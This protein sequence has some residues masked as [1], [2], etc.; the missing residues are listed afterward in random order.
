MRAIKFI[1]LVISELDITLGVDVHPLRIKIEIKTK[2]FIYTTS[3]LI[4]F[5]RLAYFYLSLIL[6]IN[7]LL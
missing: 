6:I 2:Y 3:L 5:V 4:K 7:E 1:V